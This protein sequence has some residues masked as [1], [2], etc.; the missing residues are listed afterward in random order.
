V[1]D[2][3]A[4]PDL[5]FSSLVRLER[6][7]RIDLGIRIELPLEEIRAAARTVSKTIE[8]RGDPGSLCSKGGPHCAIGKIYYPGG[9]GRLVYVKASLTGDESNY[10]IDYKRR[11]SSFPHQTTGDQFF[12]EEQ[13]EVYRALG[14]H[15]V[16]GLL[17]RDDRVA[18]VRAPADPSP[19]SKKPPFPG[20]DP[21]ETAAVNQIKGILLGRPAPAP[22]AP[23]QPVPVGT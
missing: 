8:R 9:E 23:A 21:I 14:F 22:A 7:A 20:R 18:V 1:I 3:E 19:N 12:T 11:Y 16:Y 17:E 5:H 10:V 4:D 15:E 2:G 6:Y 13:F